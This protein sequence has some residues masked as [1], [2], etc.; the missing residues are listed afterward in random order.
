MYLAF[1]PRKLGFMFHTHIMVEILA[2]SRFFCQEGME[3]HSS[4]LKPLKEMYDLDTRPSHRANGSKAGLRRGRPRPG[5][6]SGA[7]SS[8]LFH[9]GLHGLASVS[10]PP[11]SMDQSPLLLNALGCHRSCSSQHLGLG[12]QKPISEHHPNPCEQIGL[13]QLYSLISLGR[14]VHLCVCLC[15]CAGRSLWMKHGCQSLPV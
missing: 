5:E 13:I 7:A 4:N 11:L 1:E 6:L 12:N 8:T 10:T 3:T 2:Y 14:G 9:L 15:V